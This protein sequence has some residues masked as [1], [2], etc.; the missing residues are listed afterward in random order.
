MES[1]PS[2]LEKYRRETSDKGS[3]EAAVKRLGRNRSKKIL[4]KPLSF[5]NPWDLDDKGGVG[6]LTAFLYPGFQPG[7]IPPGFKYLSD[8]PTTSGGQS[9]S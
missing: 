2:S 5:L 3:P 1:S 6:H 4:K 7:F 9:G 8:E